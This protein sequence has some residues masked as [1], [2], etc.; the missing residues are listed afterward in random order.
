MIAMR[1]ETLLRECGAIM[2]AVLALVI[3]TN[4]PPAFGRAGGISREY[5]SEARILN[6]PPEV[7]A[8]IQKIAP[9]CERPLAAHSTFDRY[10]QDKSGD[11]FISLRFQ[12]LRCDHQAV[13]NASGCLQQVYMSNGGRYR[14]VWSGYAADIELEQMDPVG[15]LNVTCSVAQ[16][17][18]SRLLRW[19]GSRFAPSR[20]SARAPPSS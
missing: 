4:E 10:L 12:N 1:P 8:E 7:R 2:F 15:G 20:S 3:F 5:W 6:L 13:C 18:C 19:N 9:S 14:L 11:H 16:P 17:G